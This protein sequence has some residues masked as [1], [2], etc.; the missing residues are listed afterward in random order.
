MQFIDSF[1]Q[2]QHV[3]NHTHLAVLLSKEG[4]SVFAN[5]MH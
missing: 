4:C 3:L 5:L 2:A 1:Q